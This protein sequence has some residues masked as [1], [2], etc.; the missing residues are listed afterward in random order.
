MHNNA[1]Q[2]GSIL[3]T[4][5]VYIRPVYCLDKHQIH[6][7]FVL[8]GFPLEFSCICH[9]TIPD[10]N[11]NMEFFNFDILYLLNIIAC[12]Y[13]CIFSSIHFVS[14]LILLVYCVH[15]IQFLMFRLFQCIRW[16]S[17]NVMKV[18]IDIANASMALNIH[19]EWLLQS[20]APWN[21]AKRSHKRPHGK[22]VIYSHKAG[23][24]N[25]QSHTVKMSNAVQVCGNGSFVA[26]WKLYR[27]TGSCKPLM[28]IEK[29]H[30][31]GTCNAFEM[32]LHID[33]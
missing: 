22:N 20:I 1:Q 19:L 11:N 3:R 17:V 32:M 6:E 15:R 33:R 29:V 23:M 16:T 12:C 5:L 10:K 30:Q 18:Q 31:K 13:F 28:S 9:F 21:M 25:C 8:F 24:P 26:T 7:S 2:I 14:L 27:S 4:R